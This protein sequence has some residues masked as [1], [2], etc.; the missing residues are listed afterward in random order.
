[1]MLLV[2]PGRLRGVG[3]VLR[4]VLNGRSVARPCHAHDHTLHSMWVREKFWPWSLELLSTGVSRVRFGVCL[5]K[6]GLPFAEGYALIIPM[7]T[8]WPDCIGIRTLCG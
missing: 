4:L 2:S 8:D 3:G 6:Y 1:M 5:A 7:C